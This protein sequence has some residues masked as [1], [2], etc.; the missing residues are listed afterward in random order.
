MTLE[1]WK[2]FIRRLVKQWNK[3]SRGVVDGL[4]LE[5]VKTRLDWVLSNLINLK[6]SLFRGAG[7]NDL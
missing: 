1:M 5:T 4:T 2:L 6:M 7:L 3:L